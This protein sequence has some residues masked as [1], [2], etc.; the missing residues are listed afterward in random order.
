[1][2]V[3]FI[4][5][6]QDINKCIFNRFEKIQKKIQKNTEVLQQLIDKVS[7]LLVSFINDYIY[8]KR[9]IFFSQSK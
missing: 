1:M 5:Q 2:I 4:Q 3:T 6:Q 7:I 9:S 8:H